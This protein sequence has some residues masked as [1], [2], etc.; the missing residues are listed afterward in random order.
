MR[1]DLDIGPRPATIPPE[2]NIVGLTVQDMEK[3]LKRSTTIPCSILEKVLMELGEVDIGIGATFPHPKIQLI[4]ETYLV[5]IVMM[6]TE[7]D[8]GLTLVNY[9]YI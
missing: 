7:V 2:D 3:G 6:I 8:I 5:L 4:M 1:G 9:I